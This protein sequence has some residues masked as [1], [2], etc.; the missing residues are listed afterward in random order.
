MASYH[1]KFSTSKTEHGPRLVMTGYY[2]T[3]ALKVVSGYDVAHDRYPV[4]AYIQAQHCG[5]IKLDT[6]N[7]YGRSEHEA[8]DMGFREIEK[9]ISSN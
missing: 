1:T 4:Y 5:E 7:I 2:K 3:Y 9:W 6:T 8:F